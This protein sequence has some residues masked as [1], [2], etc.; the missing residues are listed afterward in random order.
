MAK[1]IQDVLDAVDFVARLFVLVALFGGA[2]F[3]VGLHL[4]G[5]QA[6]AFQR[7]LVAL[8]SDGGGL[9]LGLVA[10]GAFLG[11]VVTAALHRGGIQ[12][13]QSKGAATQSP[14]SSHSSSD[15]EPAKEADRRPTAQV[16]ERQTFITNK[17][18]GFGSGCRTGCG[19]LVG[20][21]VGLV[22]IFVV[23]PLFGIVLLGAA[24]TSG[25]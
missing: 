12:G 13:I 17:G 9:V 18:G 7:P 24:A 11:I 3:L 19:C 25:K 2:G 22:L 20:V 5:L 16:I 4:T 6:E 14:A 8:R 1:L 10:I 23:L 21:V 15:R